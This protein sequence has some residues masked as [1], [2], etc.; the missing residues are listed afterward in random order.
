MKKVNRPSPISLI[1]SINDDGM[2]E[3]VEK[4]LNSKNLNGGIVFNGKGT[5]ESE[6]ADIFGFGLSDKDI[7][8]V[9]V[10]KNKCPEIIKELNDITGV[11]KDRYGLNMVLDINSASSNLIEFLG[12]KID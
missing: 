6:I 5:A 10:P 7:I 8:A 1:L 9:F 3:V 12:I 11:E 2:G 4:Y